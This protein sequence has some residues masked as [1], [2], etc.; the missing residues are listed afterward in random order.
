MCVCVCVRERVVYLYLYV[1][2]YVRMCIHAYEYMHALH[3]HCA[4]ARS[5]PPTPVK[6][7][8]TT[9]V[10]NAALAMGASAQRSIVHSPSDR[11]NA[12]RWPC[13]WWGTGD[14]LAVFWRWLPA[15]GLCHSSR[16]A[17]ARAGSGLRMACVPPTRRAGTRRLATLGTFVSDRPFGR[18]S[19][20]PQELLL[21]SRCFPH[22]AQ[23]RA[24]GRPSRSGW[25]AG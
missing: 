8:H 14:R 7:G 15:C 1:C 10:S 23:P 24:F 18:Q 4:K 19:D 17:L 12:C 22:A 21:R 16:A 20:A 5:Q 9:A 3:H 2:V 11:C 25:A 6:A 13:G